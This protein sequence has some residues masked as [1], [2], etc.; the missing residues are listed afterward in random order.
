[1]SIIA[2]GH[3]TEA[4]PQ[5]SHFA[6]G[7]SDRR[8]PISSGAVTTRSTRATAPS[9]ARVRELRALALATTVRVACRF[10]HAA[11]RVHGVEA[12]LGVGGERAAERSELADDVLTAL[13]SAAVDR[14]EQICRAASTTATLPF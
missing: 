4:R 13:V 5:P 3:F 2:P 9:F 12:G 8:R 1:V 11:G 6:G 14:R 10:D 7:S